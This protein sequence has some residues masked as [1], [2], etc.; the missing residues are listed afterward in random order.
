MQTRTNFKADQLRNSHY[1]F[2]INVCIELSKFCLTKEKL[3]RK[4]VPERG[5]FNSLRQAVLHTSLVLSFELGAS[6]MVGGRG[7]VGGGGWHWFCPNKALVKRNY[8]VTKDLHI[9]LAKWVGNQNCLLE[10]SCLLLSKS[11]I[12]CFIYISFSNNLFKNRE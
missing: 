8:V 7:G 11:I 5:A 3:I 12:I 2:I 9:Q 1:Y 6:L 10:I 4:L